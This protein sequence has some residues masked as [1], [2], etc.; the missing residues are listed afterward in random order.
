MKLMEY[1]E[2]T[3]GINTN[4]GKQQDKRIQNTNEFLSGKKVCFH[5]CAKSLTLAMEIVFN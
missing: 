3:G 1:T 5:I 4:E 2:L